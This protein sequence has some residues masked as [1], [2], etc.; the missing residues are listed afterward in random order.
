MA[1]IVLISPLSTVFA[2][3][4]RILSACLKKNGHEVKLLFIIADISEQYEDNVLDEVWNFSRDADLVGISV[5]TNFFTKAVQLTQGL[6]EK[7]DVPVIWGGIH[8]T[9]R[10]VESLKYADMVCLGEGEESLVELAAKIH[11]REDFLGVPGIWFKHNG[12]I[13]RNE[14][15]PLIKDLDSIPSQDFG[16]ETHYL[17][18]DGR[19]QKIDESLLGKYMGGHYT[20]VA[21]RGCYFDCSYCA[22]NAL[23]KIN[24]DWRRI[25]KRSV[26]SIIAELKTI[27]ER[28]PFTKGVQIDDDAFFAYTEEEIADFAQQYKSNI[29]LSLGVTGI[30]PTTISRKKIQFLIDAGLVSLRMGIQSASERTKKLYNRHY[31]NQQVEEAVRLIHE[32]KDQI[33]L[34]RYD[35]ILDNPWETDEDLAATLMFL[36]RLPVPYK[37]I[38]YSLTFFPG[39]ELYE[40]ARREGIIK[41]DERDVYN[42]RYGICKETY[43]N[44][45][46]FLL[47]EYTDN[48]FGISPSIMS[49]LANRK[50]QDI[51][52]SQLLFLILKAF[53]V[54]FRPIA[55]K[56]KGFRL[57]RK[58]FKEL[59]KGNFSKIIDYLKRGSSR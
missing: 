46:F 53:T 48:S 6:K 50:M 11:N 45:L 26:A 18:S 12:E 56:R 47:A 58:G 21:S 41:D 28:L 13:I 29:G 55:L 3:G 24:Q 14:A 40:K 9:L 17:L 35:I 4:L 34:I 44:K 51:G 19:L 1:R 38:F 52:I 32:F 25:R 7:G 49:L 42:K 2:I 23:K 27:K 5:M 22:N 57:M 20:T 31:S 36:A 39:T 10:P 8:P 43:R 30:S 37:L 33:S 15:R 54:I 16:Y 59:A